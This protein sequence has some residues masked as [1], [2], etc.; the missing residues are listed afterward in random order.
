MAKMDRARKFVGKKVLY[1]GDNPI[2][3]MDLVLH[4][5]SQVAFARYD[6]QP[7]SKLAMAFRVHIISK[8]TGQLMEPNDLDSQIKHGPN[9]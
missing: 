2:Y 4:D 9:T 5:S 1:R 6:G 8:A 7:A 3:I